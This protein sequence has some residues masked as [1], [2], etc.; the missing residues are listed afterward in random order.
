MRKQVHIRRLTLILGMAAVA[1][2]LLALQISPAP[3]LG[4]EN[5]QQFITTLPGS[6]TEDYS[7][8]AGPTGNCSV[9]YQTLYS[10][11]PH[12][13]YADCGETSC[14]VRIESRW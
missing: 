11:D 8:T 1:A 7:C 6:A 13:S 2:L 4:Q 14:K 9:I 12:Q 10:L 5:V 3:A